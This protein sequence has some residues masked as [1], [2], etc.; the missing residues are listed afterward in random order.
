MK[1]IGNKTRLL[2][3][4]ERSITESKI[5]FNGTFCDIFGGTGSVGKHFKDKGFKVISND[6]MT[7]SYIIQYVLVYLNQMPMF[8]KL[9]LGD[10]KAVFQF[11][12]NLEPIE[13]YVFENYAPSGSYGRQYF[14]DINAK[15]IDAIR[16]QIQNWYNDDMLSTDE[17]FVLLSS[18]ID[19]ADFV[20]NISGTY[21]AYLKIWRSMALKPLTLRIPEIKNNNRPNEIYQED[22]NC[23]IKKIKCDVLYID[24][25][26]NERQ[27][28]SNFHVLESLAVW[29]KQ[30]LFGKTGQRDYTSKK[31]RYCLKGEALGAFSELIDCAETKYIIISYNNEGII[32][33]EKL[34]KILEK[35]GEVKEYTTNYRR[36]RTERDHEH[37]KYKNCNDKVVEHLYI[38]KV[39]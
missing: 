27:Y 8:D 20:A 12:N 13:G 17:Y 26:Y 32:P 19:A 38:V 36:F 15:R 33:R 9:A 5:P 24:P 22:A 31:S 1:Y 30:T 21:G 11:L 16:E 4:I 29:D 37:R 18:L 34:I 25:P 35:R 23:L 7:Y 39:N 3:F 2:D 6:L 28:A 10:V 14:S